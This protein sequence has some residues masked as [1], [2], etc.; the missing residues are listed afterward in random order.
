VEELIHVSNYWKSARQQVLTALRR[1]G[2]SCWMKR[3]K[4]CDTRR[5]IWKQNARLG[6]EGMARLAAT[7]ATFSFSRPGKS[8]GCFSIALTIPISLSVSL[9]FFCLWFSGPQYKLSQWNE[10]LD[11][12]II[13]L[14]AAD[15]SS[16]KWYWS[17]S[18]PAKNPLWM[19]YP[20]MV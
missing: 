18:L 1:S 4:L 6:S 13:T 9:S 7:E 19:L 3:D 12:I 10:G 11:F 20:L 2:L 8:S 5:S 16:C 14:L 15:V 17:I